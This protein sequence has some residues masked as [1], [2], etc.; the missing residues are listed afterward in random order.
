MN[1]EEQK[2]QIESM[3]WFRGEYPQY[4]MVMTHPINEGGRN[5]GRTGGIHKAEGTQAGVTDLL[6]F[7][8]AK[9]NGVIYL[10]LGIEFKRPKGGKQSQAQKDFE[11][12]FKAA[13]YE[14]V[15]V[16]YVDDFKALINTWIKHVEADLRR[17][18]AAT[19]VEITKA[20]EQREKEK[21]YKIINGK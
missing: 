16:R 7:L 2:T 3:S 9:I 8:P 12:M 11:K 5:T 10:G 17:K 19:H 18:V 6:F 4:A 21:F 14:Y 1:H 20:A 15:I 13:G